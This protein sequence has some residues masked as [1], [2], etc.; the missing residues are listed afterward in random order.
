[1]IPLPKLHTRRLCLR[2]FSTED[3][4]RVAALVN[5]PDIVRDLRTFDIPYTKVDALAWLETLQPAWEQG[6]AAVFALCLGHGS[7]APVVGAAGL[8]IDTPSQRAECGYWIG[9]DY[10]RKGI[11]S[12]ALPALLDFGF[13]QLGLNRITAE[14]LTRNVA[15]TALLTKVGF[16]REG[17]FR[18]HFRKRED[19]PFQDVIAWGFLKEEW[20]QRP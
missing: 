18:R 12:E 6:L 19:E 1:M 7:A 15:S 2:A 17:L 8:V 4:A 9:K 16:T 13:N 14:C 10:W 20:D 3:R 5:D 11:C